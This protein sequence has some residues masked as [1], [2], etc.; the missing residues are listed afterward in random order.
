MEVP[1]SQSSMIH[2]T[3]PVLLRPQTYLSTL[4]RQKCEGTVSRVA[5]LA[6]GLAELMQYICQLEQEKDDAVARGQEVEELNRELKTTI[7]TYKIFAKA[8]HKWKLGL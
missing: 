1:R 4:T 2:A 8:F 6:G 5:D 7:D 3:V